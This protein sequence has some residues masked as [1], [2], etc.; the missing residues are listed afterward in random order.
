MGLS[1]RDGL[2]TIAAAVLL[3]GS[4]GGAG[5]CLALLG[6]E[7]APTLSAL[8]LVLAV[9]LLVRIPVFWGGSVPVGYALLIALPSILTVRE[10][11]TVVLAALV[12]VV[13]ITAVRDGT[14]Q[15]GLAVARIGA[16]AVAAAGGG[17]L[18]GLV[19]DDPLVDAVGAAL[20]LVPVELAVTRRLPVDGVTIDVRSALPVLLTVLCAAALITTTQAEVGWELTV[21]AALPLLITRFA[22][23]R[24]VDAAET[25]RQ[26]V[27]ALG[28]V[29]ELAG[30]APLGS[31]ERT[32]TYAG[33][34]ARQLGCRRD[35]EERIVTACR[36]RHLGAVPHDPE[37]EGKAQVA[38]RVG[39]QTQAE[40][41]GAGA[42]I[43][44]EAGFPTRVV[45]LVRRAGAGSVERGAPDAETAIVR[46]AVA[47]DGIVGT[48]A[49]L[50]S[51]ALGYV[52]ATAVDPHTR[53]AGAALAELLATE[54]DLVRAAIAAGDAF[55]EAA[56][57]VDLDTASGEIGELV[58]FTRRL[59]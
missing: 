38:G 4:G 9:S 10:L 42:D 17:F 29:P 19:A 53:L 35:V 7:A 22:F 24:S 58:P 39:E 30:L 20:L 41:A 34:I 1:E 3:V 59:R 49:A 15:A 28:L 54:T 51:R 26:T 37:Q 55:R 31:S 32:A 33:R 45:E 57:G 16:C 40:V 56:A 44:A 5:A 47:F 52:T 23:R 11:A 36:L 8:V 50:A 13:G 14:H 43:L 2:G 6:G 18:V 46:V 25:L 48:D 27:Q 12:V 21:V